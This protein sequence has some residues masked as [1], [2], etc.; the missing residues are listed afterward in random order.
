M[1]ALLVIDV[2]N[3]FLPGGSLAVSKGDEVIEPINQ[4]M[5]LPFECIVASQDWHPKGH[6]S[7]ASTHHKNPGEVVR[8]GSVEQMLW[9]DHCIQESLGANFSS[10]LKTDLIEY[11]VQKGTSP[12]IDSYSAFFDNA[13][14]QATGLD[15]Y[16]KGQE[17][18]TLYCVGLATDYCVKFSVLDALS[19]GYS[20]YLVEEGCRAVN[21]QP[22]DENKAKEQMRQQGTQIVSMEE[23]VHSM[24][25]RSR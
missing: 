16:L 21:V 15:V 23:V 7:F 13:Y 19:L 18:D 12:Q 9:P 2:Q 1:T 10:K 17:I 8:I 20:V 6:A 22:E 11:V 3:D 5:E 24:R 25:S 4:L 14:Q